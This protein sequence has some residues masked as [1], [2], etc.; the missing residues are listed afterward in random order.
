MR[1]L[2]SEFRR[3]VLGVLA[4]TIGLSNVTALP[5]VNVNTDTSAANPVRSDTGSNIGDGK[6]SNRTDVEADGDA[7]TDANANANSGA[8]VQ[9]NSINDVLLDNV[10]ATLHA[11]ETGVPL[12]VNPALACIDAR[13]VATPPALLRLDLANKLLGLDIDNGPTHPLSSASLLQD[14]TNTSDTST[15][16]PTKY[17]LLAIKRKAVHTERDSKRLKRGAM[18]RLLPEAALWVALAHA[19]DAG[20]RHIV[21]T[22]AVMGLTSSRKKAVT[23]GV[24]MPQA[25][26]GHETGADASNSTRL[27]YDKDVWRSAHMDVTAA[28]PRGLAALAWRVA[29]VDD[30]QMWIERAKQTHGLD[31][32]ADRVVKQADK[33]YV[34]SD[35]GQVEPQIAAM[36]LGCHQKGNGNEHVDDDNSQKVDVENDNMKDADGLKLL[37]AHPTR[38]EHRPNMKVT[39]MY[40][41]PWATAKKLIARS[42]RDLTL[43]SGLSNVLAGEALFGPLP[44]EGALTRNNNNTN[45]KKAVFDIKKTPDV[46]D[47]SPKEL[48]RRLPNDYAHPAVTAAALGVERPFTMRLLEMCKSTY[49]GPAIQP[50][51][52]SHNLMNWRLLKSFRGRGFMGA[53]DDGNEGPGTFKRDGEHVHRWRERSFFVDFELASPD[54]LRSLSPSSEVHPDDTGDVDV[55]QLRKVLDITPAQSPHAYCENEREV[56]GVAAGK[57]QDPLIFMIGCGRVVRRRRSHLESNGSASGSSGGDGSQEEEEEDTW[58]YRC[59]TVKNM[60]LVQEQMMLIEWMQ[61]MKQCCSSDDGGGESGEDGNG[62]YLFVWGPE[63]QLLKKAV[64]RILDTPRRDYIKSIIPVHMVNMLTVVMNADLVVRGSMNQAI[65]SVAE[66]LGAL[67]HV[68]PHLRLSNV[69]LDVARADDRSVCNAMDVMAVAL[70]AAELVEKTNREAKQKQAQGDGSMAKEMVLM[71]VDAMKDVRVY[72]EADCLDIARITN[73]LRDHH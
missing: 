27:P 45:K 20:R 16:K 40:D 68:A 36:A 53:L 59:F 26:N 22:V 65:K 2:S 25:V 4:R 66:A 11:M 23:D 70:D 32:K 51:V 24:I 60:G 67:P 30:G 15:S 1:A 14:A 17:C 73:F 28:L 7:A 33:I 6:R 44:N 71:D 47:E 35:Q 3:H 62:A 5:H 31:R 54:V 34:T 72:N 69:P 8:D 38:H 63:Q 61:W 58:E 37:A 43:I 13:V 9:G 52:I 64:G 10:Q 18:D 48:Q 42:V 39:D 41:W 29:A 50:A 49:K 12:I 56:V 57:R 19:C 21:P 46:G 55:E